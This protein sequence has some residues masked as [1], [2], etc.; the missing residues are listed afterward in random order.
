MST[1]LSA[2]NERTDDA[3]LTDDQVYQLKGG[4]SVFFTKLLIGFGTVGAY[5]FLRKRQNELL[6]FEISRS[7]FLMSNFL[8]FL[9]T[10][11]YQSFYNISSGNSS[12]LRLHQ[13]ALYQR[14]LINYQFLLSNKKKPKVH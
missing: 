3:L 10:I 6:R 11:T 9:S 4:N 14:F 8:F 12:R 1:Y 2:L 5:L 7:A 13:A